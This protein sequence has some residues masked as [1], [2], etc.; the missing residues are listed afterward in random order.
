MTYLRLHLVTLFLPLAIAATFIPAVDGEEFPLPSTVSFTNDV[1][2]VLTKY[3]CDYGGCHG[4]ATGQNGFRLSLFGT[5]AEESYRAIVLNAK[6][7]RVF[8]GSPE[9]SLVLKK[10]TGVT[11]HGGG[12]RFDVNSAAY[13]TLARWI[14]DGMP[15]PDQ[16]SVKLTGLEWFPKQITLRPGQTQAISV[17]A[18]YS[19]GTTRD[20][21]EMTLYELNEDGIVTVSPDGQI[22]IVG[23]GGLAAVIVKYGQLAGTVQVTVPYSTDSNQSLDLTRQYEALTAAFQGNPLNLSLLKQWQQ[24]QILPSAV[25]DDETFIRRASLDISGTLPTAEQVTRF[26]ANPAAVSYTHLTLPTKA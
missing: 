16:N 18:S 4:K 21:S 5:D 19:N 2:P 25:C 24:L 10:A 22:E 11:A 14:A 20:V 23:N 17:I 1:M 6:G 9:H 12:K 15:G 8:P 26:V 7:R 3:S 13:R